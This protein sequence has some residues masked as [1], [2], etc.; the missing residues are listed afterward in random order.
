MDQQTTDKR[1]HAIPCVTAMI[2]LIL[3]LLPW[4]YGYFQFLRLVVTG[5]AAW[6]AYIAHT[7][8]KPKL[9]TVFIVIALLF[10]P[11]I[12][13]HLNRPLWI[14]I[15]LLC[16]GAFGLTLMLYERETKA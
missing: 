14:M 10:N 7:D 13:I 8:T 4:P 11:F 6:V 15:D 16:A 5:T 1:P 9:R 3:A 12:P 2:F